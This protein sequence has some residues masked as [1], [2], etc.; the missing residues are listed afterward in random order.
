MMDVMHLTLDELVPVGKMAIGNALKNAVI[1]EYLAD[2][3]YTP[4]RLAEGQTLLSAAEKLIGTQV[5]G[6]GDQKNATEVKDEAW[7]AADKVYMRLI[8]SA[9]LVIH[10][11]GDRTALGLDGIR[12]NSY[13]GWLGQVKQFYTQALA[14]ADL[15][16]Q[17][18]D[19]NVT[20]AKLQAGLALVT[21]LEAARE[22]QQ[23]QIGAKQNATEDRDKVLDDLRAWLSKYLAVAE[24]ALEDEPQLLESLGVLVRS[25]AARPPEPPAAADAS[26]APQP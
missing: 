14:R 16:D 11:S 23:S 17:L 22:T 20:A 8:K 15:L 25:R 18:D 19:L 2:F 21:A 6:L 26:P 7:E 1:M 4:D 12:R 13:L 10:K 24:L 5:G 3:K 9:R